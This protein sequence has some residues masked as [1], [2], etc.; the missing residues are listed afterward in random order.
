MD[1]S[2][3]LEWMAGHDC[4]LRDKKHFRSPPGSV[5]SGVLPLIEIPSC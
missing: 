3:S 4:C 1:N 5:S 2:R